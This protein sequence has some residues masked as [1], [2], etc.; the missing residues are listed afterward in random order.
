MYYQQALIQTR[1]QRRKRRV[2]TNQELGGRTASSSFGPVTSTLFLVVVAVILAL[3]YL[4]QI[5]KTSVYGYQIDE[6]N[7]EQEV[8]VEQRQELQV[9][10]ARLQSVARIEDSSVR[11]GLEPETNVTYDNRQ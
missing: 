6:L 3:L 2:S 11:A 7:N 10:A 5:T 4:T 8:L 1:A 9:E